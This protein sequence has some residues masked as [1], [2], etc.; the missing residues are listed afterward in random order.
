MCLQ[1]WRMLPKPAQRV[2]WYYYRPGQE[3]DKDPSTHYLLAQA[4]AVALVAFKDK[5]WG[6]LQALN[7]VARAS[8]EAQR[9]GVDL[10]R[11]GEIIRSMGCDRIAR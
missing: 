8:A 4:C 3:N 11:C 7:H 1:H 5:T 2:I 9:D 10:T 6:A